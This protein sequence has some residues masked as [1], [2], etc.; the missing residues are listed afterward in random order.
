[1]S[2]PVLMI[3]ASFLFATMSVCVKLASELYATGEIVF[4]RGTVGALTLAL[5]TWRQGGTLRTP[6]PAMHFWRSISGVLALGL[7]FY[8]IGNLPLATAMTLNYMSSVW[9]ALFLI[10]GAVMLGTSRVDGRLIATVLLG[11]AGV[12]LILRPTIE[13]NQLWHGLIGLISGM[14]AATAYLQ[15]TALGRAG[16]P[17]YRIVFYFSLGSMLLGALTTFW[18]G[19]QGHTWRGAALL[20][21][22]GVLATTAQM[23]MTRAYSTGKMLVNASLQYLGIAFSFV[24]G[25][26]LFNDKITWMAL[27]GMLFIVCS[28]L[29]ATLLRSKTAFANTTTPTES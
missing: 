29:A 6:V 24:Y 16:E 27:L 3:L 5:L 7:W 18:T 11:F 23:L 9:M 8:A 1:M 15:V 25:V 28:G 17:V 22:V 20:L 19:F 4:Y 26:L 2:A 12:A 10:G 13:E 14:I 21:A